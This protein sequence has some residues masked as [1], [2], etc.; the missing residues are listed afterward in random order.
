MRRA[1]LSLRRPLLRRLSRVHHHYFSS[2]SIARSG[3]GAS[4]QSSSVSSAGAA[5]SV[6]RQAQHATVNSSTHTVNRF[7]PV[8][9]RRFSTSAADR[10]T[11]SRVR[12]HSSSGPA[13]STLRLPMQIRGF[14]AALAAAAVAGGAYYLRSSQQNV[15]R[16]DSPTSASGTD[17]STAAVRR[18]LVVEAGGALYDTTFT[19]DG[20]LSKETDDRGRKVLEMLNPQQATE[21]LR[22][23]EE[24]WL[25]G[26]GTGVTRFDLVQL[27]SNDPIE[28]D[29]AEKL[30]QVPN[31]VA[32]TEDGSANS[33][34]MF[35]GVFDGHR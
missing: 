30:I 20:P 29:H 22:R 15:I 25:V 9:A 1:A 23:T 21:R 33:D 10:F 5:S 35:W 13:Y 7:V 8:G 3:L 6:T 31:T 19:G 2:N 28:D 4:S 14:S 12:A 34:W 18:G 16:A 17:P 24:S 27:P 11:S 26:R 32:A